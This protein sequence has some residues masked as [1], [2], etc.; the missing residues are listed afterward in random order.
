MCASGIAGDEKHLIS[1]RLGLQC[2]KEQRPN[3]FEGPQTMLASFHV[4]TARYSNWGCQ[5][6]QCVRFAN[7]PSGS[8]I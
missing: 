6:R 2:F 1:E 5:V 3:F 8:S 4:A 7:E